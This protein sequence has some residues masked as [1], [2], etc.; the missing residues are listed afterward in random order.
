M[1]PTR[2]DRTTEPTPV[3]VVDE[4]VEHS[5]LN[6]LSESE[7]GYVE[8]LLGAAVTSVEGYTGQSLGEQAWTAYF[9]CWPRAGDRLL[10]PRGPVTAVSAVKYRDEAGVLQTLGA[11]TYH[12]DVGGEMADGVALTDGA[13]WPLLTSDRVAPVSVEYATGY[14]APLEIPPALRVAIMQLA[15]HWYENREPVVTGTIAT[16][17]PMHVT[18]LIA[19]HDR[20]LR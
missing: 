20:R 1:K 4:F 17:L 10:L 2:W 18:A 16:P 13:T 7:R 14:V 3:V 11:S 9:P 12:L 6:A 19:Q 15:A 8:L 5:R